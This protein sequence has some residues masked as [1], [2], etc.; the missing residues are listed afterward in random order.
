MC[1]RDRR[2]GDPE[3]LYPLPDEEWIV[4]HCR[5]GQFRIQ[6]VNNYLLLV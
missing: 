4:K 1:I 6:V 5:Y 3:D 2:K